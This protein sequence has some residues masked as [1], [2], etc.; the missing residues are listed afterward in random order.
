MI[1]REL[2]AKNFQEAAEVL[3]EVWEK[4][5]MDGYPVNFKAVSVGNL[6]E[7]LTPGLVWVALST[8]LI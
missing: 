6:Y 2:E 4:T 5:V 8:F 1:D 3:S 7:P